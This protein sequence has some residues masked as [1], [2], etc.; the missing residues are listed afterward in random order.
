MQSLGTKEKEL[1]LKLDTENMSATQVRLVK[2]IHALLA[3]VLA[4]EEE[5][6]YFEA[7]AALLKKTSEVI[8]VANYSALNKHMPYGE[9]A[10][11]FA[12]DSLNESL[13][14]QTL[15]N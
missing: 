10:V 12:V 15:D 9:Q 13:E 6:E 5:G 14:L 11:E 3:H 2:Q 4:S 8:K 1:L 7:S